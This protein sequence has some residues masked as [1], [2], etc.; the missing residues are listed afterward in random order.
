MGTIVISGTVV[1]VVLGFGNHVWWLAAVAVLFLYV[2]YGRGASSTSSSGG[3]S[4]GGASGPVPGDYRAYRDRRD[5]QAK[6]ERR[7]RRER[8]FESRR[9][10]REKGK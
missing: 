10:A 8:P 2:Q 9:Q 3:A 4:S 5:R 6:W 7:Y 1:L